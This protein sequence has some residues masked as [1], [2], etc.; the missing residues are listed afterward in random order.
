MEDIKKD[1]FNSLQNAKTFRKWKKN[2][3]HEQFVCFIY[4]MFKIHPYYKSELQHI[5]MY[6]QTPNSVI[7]K[8]NLND[9][10]HIICQLGDQ[11]YGVVCCLHERTSSGDASPPYDNPHNSLIN[12][13]HVAAKGT[14]K[15]TAKNTFNIYGDFWKTINEE[16]M[17]EIKFLCI[18]K[19]VNYQKSKPY[20]HQ[21]EAINQAIT[22]YKNNR[23][24]ILV[25]ACGTG[26][27]LTSY[28]ICRELKFN[29]II[30]C[31]PSLHLLSQFYLEW[32]K[33]GKFHSL[34]IGSDMDGAVKSTHAGGSVPGLLLTTNREIISKWMRKH[35]NK[36]HVI[37][38]TY[39]SSHILK[40]ILKLDEKINLKT[41][42]YNYDICIYD[43]A[44]KTVNN[45][46]TGKNKFNVLVTDRLDIRSKLFMTA[47]PK[48]HVGENNQIVSM[49]NSQVYG[50]IFYKL[51]LR[52]AIDEKLLTEYQIITPIASK[53]QIDQYLEQYDVISEQQQKNTRIQDIASAIMLIKC[54]LEHGC[55]HILTYHTTIRE[56][57]IFS[58]LIIKLDEYYKLNIYCKHLDG[59][60]NMKKRSKIFSAFKKANIAIM[61]SARVL[62]EGVDIPVVDSVCFVSPRKSII[63]IIQSIGRCLRLYKGKTKSSIIIPL[64]AEN[65]NTTKM[66]DII[67]AIGNQDNTLAANFQNSNG[68]ESKVKY[69][70]CFG[71]HDVGIDIKFKEIVEGISIKCYLQLD[72]WTLRKE[73]LFK[74]CD[75]KKK[76]P[77]RMEVYEHVNLGT[78]YICEQRKIQSVKDDNYKSLSV[79]KYVKKSLDTYLRKN[80]F[81]AK[82]QEIMES[83]KLAVNNSAAS[84]DDLLN[85]YFNDTV[86]WDD[87]LKSLFKFCNINQRVPKRNEAIDGYQIG[88]WYLKQIKDNSKHKILCKNKY[89]KNELD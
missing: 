24:G 87:M 88:E 70:K 66:W 30:I 81:S 80:K 33:Q 19:K 7:K 21:Q 1:L 13:I 86:T 34:L 51:N 45:V 27:T 89:I 40:D 36:R 84:F 50:K 67:K 53:E 22:H 2:T 39:H 60:F 59:S 18:N 8:F 65:E 75:I 62:N 42:K 61:C 35:R 10:Y 74:Y 3:N 73:L 54:I 32:S 77:V 23:N 6:N 69:I 31:V 15:G 55:A 16:M 79:N 12:N 78:W 68:R 82:S 48:F 58:K 63:D 52:K 43:E 14:A 72:K 71:K 5:Y 41:H 64:I 85:V 38:C 37:L 47:T 46:Q 76:T 4:Y 56:S 9:S 11:W 44:H 29:K 28:F 57:E 17:N 20:K 25:M 49:K 26:K 83:S